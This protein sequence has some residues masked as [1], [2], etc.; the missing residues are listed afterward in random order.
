MTV[1]ELVILYVV[2]LLKICLKFLEIL[3]YKTAWCAP[4]FFLNDSFLCSSCNSNK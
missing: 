2:I 4:D 1:K 3:K